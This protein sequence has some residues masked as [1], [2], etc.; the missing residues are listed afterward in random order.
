MMSFSFLIGCAENGSTIEGDHKHHTDDL[1]RKD[2]NP[3][4]SVENPSI[5]YVETVDDNIDIPGISLLSTVCCLSLI[6]ICCRFLS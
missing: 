1:D 2:T 6:S 3:S 4:I 5:E